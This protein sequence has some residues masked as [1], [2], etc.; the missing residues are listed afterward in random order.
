MP[1]PGS[2]GQHV[3][4]SGVLSIGLWYRLEAVHRSRRHEGPMDRDPGILLNPQDVP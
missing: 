3:P 1:D 2:G 4:V